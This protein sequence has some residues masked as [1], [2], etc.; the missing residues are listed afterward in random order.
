HQRAA[1]RA[2]P[3]LSGAD[4]PSPRAR[5]AC[6]SG[7]AFS[8]LDMH[9]RTGFNRSAWA[10]APRQALSKVGL[11]RIHPHPVLA[12]GVAFA[13]RYRLVVQG[14]EVHGDAVRRSYLVLA[15]VAAADRAR[16]VEVDVPPLAQLG[17]QVA[18]L[19]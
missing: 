9:V 13:D 11:Q 2:L 17:G 8:R 16:V 3:G 15:A 19:G 12:H 14:L 10:S 6:M 1:S 18:G 4:Q 5:A 7:K